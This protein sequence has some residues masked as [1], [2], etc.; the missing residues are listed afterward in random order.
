MSL[1]SN[2]IARCILVS[3]FC[4]GQTGAM[5]RERGGGLSSSQNINREEDDLDD[6]FETTVNNHFNISESSRSSDDD[7]QPI[8]NIK[9][10]ELEA[11]GDL[12]RLRRALVRMKSINEY[13]YTIRLG[14]DIYFIDKTEDIASEFYSDSPWIMPAGLMSVITKAKLVDM[15]E[16][17]P[18][19]RVRFF[20]NITIESYGFMPPNLR[21]FRG[22]K[23]TRLEG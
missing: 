14:G 8:Q 16:M 3:S 9:C 12:E 2:L 19:K 4:S 10:P 11:F 18:P 7:F 22:V 1:N 15:E 13:K 6:S 21:K 5:D 23:I 17:Q 20:Y